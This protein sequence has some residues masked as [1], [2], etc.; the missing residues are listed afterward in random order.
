MFDIE[1]RVGY[2]LEIMRET[3]KRQFYASKLAKS[4]DQMINAEIE[5][6][7]LSHGY[8]KLMHLIFV[9]LEQ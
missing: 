8:R 6:A 3:L 2:N 7:S 9:D 1:T 5:S 4:K